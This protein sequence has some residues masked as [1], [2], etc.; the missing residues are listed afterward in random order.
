MSLSDRITSTEDFQW[1][2]RKSLEEGLK[3][4]TAALRPWTID[5]HIAQND[6]TVHGSG[7]HDKTGKDIVWRQNPNGK[8]AVAF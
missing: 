8:L 1:S 2:D 5:F 6:G 4:L 7:S 3:K